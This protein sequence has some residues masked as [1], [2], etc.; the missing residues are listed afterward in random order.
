MATTGDEDMNSYTIKNN[1]LRS[2]QQENFDQLFREFNCTT[3]YGVE[4]IID[5]LLSENMTNFTDTSRSDW[6]GLSDLS[7]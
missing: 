1:M 4:Y 6:F 5:D 7:I 3:V 2:D